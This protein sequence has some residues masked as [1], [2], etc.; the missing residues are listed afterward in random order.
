MEAIAFQ[1]SKLPTSTGSQVPTVPISI[2]P[3]FNILGVLQ[4]FPKGSAAGPSGLR[5][6]HLLDAA[7]IPL[8]TSICSSLRDLVN[9]LSSGKAPTSV[10][11]FLA[12]GSLTA[13]NKFK[14]GCLPDVR[15]IA[16]GEALRRLTE[17]CLCSL[18]KQVILDECALHFPEL[19][20]WATW[21]YAAHPL[22]WHPM[23]RIFSETGV[24]Q[25]DPLGPLLFALVLQK[26]LN[27]IDADDDCIHILYQAWY[28][29]DGTL[30]GKKSA[31]LRALS[32][33]DSIGPSLG[34]FIN[35]SKCELFCKGDT[36]EF[37]P[38]MKSSHVPHLDLLGAPIGDYLFCGKYAASKRSEALKL[39]SRLVEVGASDPQVALILLHLCGSYCKLIHLARATPPS[40]VSEALQLFDAEVR[41][42][43]A[44]SIA[45]EVT[46]R[47]WQ[48]AQLNL[49]HGGLGLRSV[50][51]HSS[52][53]YIASLCA[54]GFGDAQNPH[55]SHTVD[56]FNKLVSP[57]E[58]IS[59]D[60]ITTSP[61][62]QRVLS[63]K[64]EDH[65][66]SLLLE[67]SSP[68]D[69]AQLL[70][71]SAPH[72]ASWLLT[73]ASLSEGAA[74]EEAEVRKHRA[75]D[76]KCSELGWVC[77]PLAVETYG[78][79]G[80]EAQSTFSRLASHLAIIT[81]SHKSKVLTELYSRLNFTL[82]QAVARALLIYDD[83]LRA[84]VCSS[85]NIQLAESDPSW[86]QSTLPVRHGGLGIRSA[87][88]LAHSAFLASAAASSGLAHLILPAN[89]QPPQLSYVD[90]ALAAWSQGC[91][92]QPP[93]DAAA[94]HQKTWD[95]IR[96]PVR[97]NALPVTSLG[98]RMDNATMRISMGLCLGLPLCQSHNCQHCGAEVSQFATHGLSCRKSAGRHHRHSAVKEI[99]HRALVSAHIPS[100]LEPSGLYRS[101]GKR[102]DG[103]SIVP[104][105]CGQLLVWDATCPDT[106][107]PSYS[108]IAAHQVGAVTQQA[109]DRK[110]QKYKHLYSC[111]FFTPVAIETS[112]V[113]GPKIKE[114]LK[115]LGFRLRQVS[116]KANSFAYLTQRLSVAIQ[117]GNA[118]SVLGTIKMDSEEEEFLV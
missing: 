105:K 44:Q 108:T 3:D 58:V 72:A 34:I 113:F 16:V 28:L 99:I 60:A 41:Q 96:R 117:R 43:F 24:Q 18:I 111:Y 40:L 15:P 82:V 49:S 4:S 47:A 73:A 53:A 7:S 81:S 6:Q 27:A 102:P 106:F 5:I 80:R 115:E 75:N 35:M 66:F 71:V 68:A 56:L 22:L 32:L 30:A 37:P 26:I 14:P 94:H 61:V 110:M 48:Q 45:V 59:V 98:L 10:S 109:E 23:G 74:V 62:Q 29:D 63:K 101:N 91:Q 118:A 77:I 51:H 19:L 114:F 100:R 103:V 42:C 95:T 36:S 8:P 46:D 64:L 21:C 107:A 9:L 25:G 39:L 116:G 88:Q 55:L 33:L 13:L 57:S 112:G 1:A 69:K 20:P 67:A 85:F 11:T 86:T 89:M 17:K 65:Q 83:E 70:S 52:A 31:I 50:S 87:V 79:W 90:E 2:G 38:S 104:W 76:P 93:T 78:N 12:G 84:T 97:L 54:S 92:E